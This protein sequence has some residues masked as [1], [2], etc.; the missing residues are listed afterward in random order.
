MYEI[1]RET[2][3]DTRQSGAVIFIALK[4]VGV[5]SQTICCAFFFDSDAVFHLTRLP[6]KADDS[7]S[8]VGLSGEKH[9]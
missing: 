2:E 8:D 3:I 1:D 4:K 5:P 7:G 9:K 6:G